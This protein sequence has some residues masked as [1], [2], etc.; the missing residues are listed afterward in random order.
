MR[1]AN[2]RNRTSSIR[3]LVHVVL[4]FAL[5]VSSLGHIPALFASG[6]AQA[7]SG[8][9]SPPVALSA[10]F[11]S[12][13][14]LQIAF[15]EPVQLADAQDA[16]SY[17]LTS[18]TDR[19]YAQPIAPLSASLAG[20]G[21]SVLLTVSPPL[22]LGHGYVVFLSGIMDVAGNQIDPES[23]LVLLAPPPAYQ[24]SVDAAQEVYPF[25]PDIRGAQLVTWLHAAG[26]KPGPNEVANLAEVVAP[27]D[28]GVIRFAGGLWANDTGWDRSNLIQ[29][30]SLDI[31]FRWTN[32]DTGVEHPTDYRHVYNAEMMDSL[33]A[34]AQALGTDVIIQV[35]ICDNNPAMWADLVHYTNVE[36]DYA[37]KYWELGN[38]LSLNPFWKCL[39]TATDDEAA[40][41]YAELFVE[42]REALVA[43]DPTIQLMG[44]TGHQ[45]GTT[46]LWV[47]PLLDAL[48]LAG[49][50]LDV[51]S[52]H[53]YPMWDPPTPA[54]VEANIFD[55]DVRN[56][57]SK[58]TMTAVNQMLVD[59]GSPDALTAITELNTH[60]SDNMPTNG[61]HI[62]AL[63]MLD[64]LP[65]LAYHGLDMNI[66]YD[67]YDHDDFEM[68]YGDSDD[69]AELYVRPTYYSMLM[70]SQYFGD[71]MIQSATSDPKELV[72]VW[73]SNV[74]DDP[75]MI[76]LIVVNMSDTSADVDIDVSGFAVGSGTYYTLANANP[77]DLSP[78]S[79][80]GGSTI[81]GAS[82]DTAFG[83]VQPSIDA[84]PGL[85]LTEIADGT[86]SH[87]LPPFSGTAM[88]LNTA[89]SFTEDVTP[90]TASL[91]PHGLVE[92]AAGPIAFSAQA[93]DDVGVSVVRFYVDGV[94]IST[95]LAGPF[96]IVWDSTDALNGTHIVTVV[97]ED[98][99]G[100]SATD[101]Q[102]ISTY[103]GSPL[104]LR[105]N[106]GS[107][108]A[109]DSSGTA[110]LED[111]E[112]GYGEPWGHQGDPDKMVAVGM[113]MGIG[114]TLDDGLY[115]S[116]LWGM[117]SYNIE[118]PNGS[119]DVRFLFSETTS[120]V[121][122]PG[123]HIFDVSVE[124]VLILDDLD[125]AA[126]VGL[127]YALDKIVQDVEVTDGRLDIDFVASVERT[128]VKA[129]EILPAGGIPEPTATADPAATATPTATPDASPSVA[130]DPAEVTVPGGD[131]QQFS[132]T[133]SGV[134]DESVTWEIVG[135][136]APP[137][138]GSFN[139][140]FAWDGDHAATI[141]GGTASTVWWNADAWDARSD[142]A[143]NPMNYDVTAGHYIDIQRGTNDPNSGA[144]DNALAIG[145][146]GSPGVGIMHLDFEDIVSARLRNTMLISADNPGVVDFRT[147]NFV[148]TGHWWE[149]AIAPANVVTG[150][151]FTAVPNPTEHFAGNPGS[152]HY[153]ADD[154]INFVTVGESDV[155]C[156]SGW[157]VRLGV[158]KA[159]DHTARQEIL[160]PVFPTDPSLKDQL[161][162]WR[163]V[164]YPDHIEAHVDLDGDGTLETVNTFDVVIPW[165]EVNVYLMG[166]GY[167]AFKHP[168]A[169][170]NQGQTRD[171]PWRDVSISP[172]KYDRTTA[173]PKENGTTKTPQDTGWI[174]Y[175]LRDSMRFGVVNGIAQPNAGQ[176]DRHTS[177][178]FCSDANVYGCFSSRAT[179]AK[180]LTFDLPA[181]DATGIARARLIYD[182]RYTGTASLDV[183]GIPVGPMPGWST[184]PAAVKEQWV[185]RSI[186]V[187]PGL[188][189]AGENSITVHMADNV[190]MDRV[191]LEFGYGQPELGSISAQGLYTAPT[192]WHDT[193]VTIRTRSVEDPTIFADAVVTLTSPVAAPPP[194]PDDSATPT[195]TPTPEPILVS[196]E[197]GTVNA[198]VRTSENDAFHSPSGYPGYSE[199]ATTVLAGARGSSG[200]TYGGWRWADIYVPAE[201]RIVEAY[202]ELNQAGWGNDF[203]TT[204]ALEDAARPNQFSRAD[205]P[206]IRWDNRT[207][208]SAPWN[209][210]KR[211]PST[212]IRT[213]SLVVGIQELVDKHGL[214]TE[215]VLLESGV[216]V[217]Q[218]LYHEWASVDL[219][220]ARAA[221][222]H[223][224]YEGGVEGPAPTPTSDPAPEPTPHPTPTPIPGTISVEA[225]VSA[226]LDDAYHAPGGWPAY[227]GSTTTVL[228]GARGA[229]GPTWGGWRWTG[230]DVPAGV[231]IVDA[232][233][234]F[235]QAG[236]G[237]A[238]TTTLAFQDAAVTQSFTSSDSPYDR[239]SSRTVFEADWTWEKASPGSWIRTPSLAT[240]VQELL[241]KYG[242][243]SE[244]VLLE[245][246][247][248]VTQTLYHE[249]A[250]YDL[251]PTR[252]PRLVVEYLVPSRVLN[253][254]VAS[255]ADDA[256]H[257]PGGWPGY[258]GTAS[259]VLA[260]ARSSNGPTYGGW[261]WT[262]LGLPANVEITDAYV[263]FNQAGW[264]NV[265]P[266]TLAFQD[267]ASPL[268]F[269]GVDSPFHRWATRTTF[270][271]DWTWDKQSSSSWI[272][273]PSLTAGIQ[274]LVDRY[275]ALNE[276]A[277][278]ESG[279]PAAAGL[280][281]EWAAFDLDPGRSAILHIEFSFPDG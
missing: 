159:M 218:N 237:S 171:I 83:Q 268:A 142:T 150:A 221:K 266:T 92:P 146:D 119:Y 126:E 255:S 15:N 66:W 190:Q 97:A 276:I 158:T 270:Q 75:D 22:T 148:T 223:I 32:P 239:W 29:E 134:T 177:L 12:P 250:S 181:E 89:P 21:D 224:V 249:W 86:V 234:E 207:A 80:K 243:L 73:A 144:L 129:I 41:R 139:E 100:N 202:V 200:P 98:G 262:D 261:R 11:V 44:P 120:T 64:V 236:Y 173:Y 133:V 52:W 217:A 225:Q 113:R 4:V 231:Q 160:G 215:I 233:V 259:T 24:L 70:L 210:E 121:S 149:I 228:S 85:P 137:P 164:Y 216:G 238:V 40:V 123:E 245:D 130:I 128:M 67:L 28:M 42:Y 256:Y 79:L 76:K 269:A 204:I 115:A 143:H 46:R 112:Y 145:G 263:E 206:Y 6:N 229:N 17:A 59:G 125:I 43:V 26:R 153:P 264:G 230:I 117:D 131:T 18:P 242:T 226:S 212:W 53:R 157:Q 281:H 3:K 90:P 57:M 95:Q 213:P 240:G 20:P 87:T 195:P 279:E 209:W 16:S 107:S 38:E 183:N 232:Y 188:F 227:A 63:W 254:P 1:R 176:Y 140:P 118:L 104:P 45:P 156:V 197:A 265:F 13:D 166:V 167:Q 51:V 108:N 152:G 198:Q 72:G 175:D 178:A 205:S 246:G 241:D 50:D 93:S 47:P 275:G 81:N 84:I 34:F 5:V 277:L 65:R 109:I 7:E 62:G 273:S 251:D 106:S 127:R 23:R 114:G 103:R 147:T 248:G 138:A 161:Y 174:S 96:E 55:L 124:G 154:S 58:Q 71:V 252:A 56:L 235:S 136:N 31:P 201:A 78:E 135:D 271:L 187:P 105:I 14:T 260:G 253:V 185:Q 69:P 189:H 193:P 68:V 280:Y 37:F 199:T 132:A 39:G 163:L 151:E 27:L 74:A 222:L 110:W 141:L 192:A 219:D 25:S 77:I 111:Q 214:L 54:L 191:Q 99:A 220:T 179:P 122:G 91:D 203:P 88:I 60:V 194:A 182:T 257:A 48:D 274:E 8:D 180:T 9:F 61:N 30:W 101:S 196:D 168:Q 162:H 116:G 82:V 36:N 2:R 186:D 267:D 19:A 94:L 155:P 10:A 165:S 278:L 211:A 272:R 33:G 208:F 169:E 244:F 247:T 184:V 49:L 170:C 172:V 35:N 258:S 102:L